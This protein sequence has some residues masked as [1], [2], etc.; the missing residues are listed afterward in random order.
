[1]TASS[2]APWRPADRSE[3]AWWIRGRTTAP[4][5]FRIF[6]LPHAGAVPQLYLQWQRLLPPYIELVVLQLPRGDTVRERHELGD[7]LPQFARQA[8]PLLTVP[9]VFFGHSFGAILAFEIVRQLRQHLSNVR[10]LVASGCI[11]P[12]H[13]P[14]AE[15]VNMSDREIMMLLDAYYQAELDQFEDKE[16][17][18]EAIVPLVKA[19][20]GLAATYRYRPERRLPVPI[21]VRAGLADQHTPV[22]QL[23]G[24]AQETTEEFILRRFEGGHFFY[25]RA[26]PDLLAFLTT[27]VAGG[28]T[29]KS[30][31][32][33]LI[34][35]GA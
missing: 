18:L 7:L 28:G 30:E 27:E 5:K 23:L 26:V 14:P 20:I 4:V 3:T 29:T 12:C 33:R 25:L 21:T 24:W 13:W 35:A 22:G 9:A 17:I 16:E 34:A 32:C 1:M 11:A 10:G 31:Q 2:L 6:C 8:E 15:V 19:D